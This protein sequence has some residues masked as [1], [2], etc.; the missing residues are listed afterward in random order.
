MGSTSNGERETGTRAAY[1]LTGIVGTTDG[2][3]VFSAYRPVFRTQDG[4]EYQ[5]TADEWST[6]KPGTT[7]EV[8][9][10]DA[11]IT[12]I[13]TDRDDRM[14]ILDGYLVWYAPA[15]LADAIERSAGSLQRARAAT[16]ARWDWEKTPLNVRLPGARIL[17]WEWYGDDGARI[18][19]G[20]RAMFD[21]LSDAIYKTARNE[22]LPAIITG[23]ADEHADALDIMLH[24]EPADDALAEERRIVLDL[25]DGHTGDDATEATPRHEPQD[26]YLDTWKRHIRIY[27]P[28]SPAP[29][30]H[31]ETQHA[32]DGHWIVNVHADNP[33]NGSHEWVWYLEQGR[34]DETEEQALE[35]AREF[36]RKHPIDQAE[37]ARLINESRA[38]D[39]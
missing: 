12:R 24:T 19:T 15:E 20:S 17:G 31:A 33:G 39:R 11:G 28:A 18:T 37:W 27:D 34:C 13:P 26:D 16:E 2:T 32:M 25:H 21:A 30:L 22:L 38:A 4:T 8:K 35:L 6:T 7:K 5:A 14:Y 36:I 9:P 23:H 29:T 1:T 10:G 3:D